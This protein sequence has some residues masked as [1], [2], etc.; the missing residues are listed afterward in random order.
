MKGGAGYLWAWEFCCPRCG[1]ELGG[2]LLKCLGSGITWQRT[3]PEIQ[4]QRGWRGDLLV[5]STHRAQA[6]VWLPEP[7]LG[8]VQPPV[9]LAPG[10]PVPLVSEGPASMCTYPTPLTYTRLKIKTN[11][12]EQRAFIKSGKTSPQ[13]S[14]EGAPV[15][16]CHLTYY[17]C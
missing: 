9:T 14:R 11:L 17:I 5:K 15:F 1:S 4:K 6:R 10:D 3:G 8:R 2:H 16:L 13:P 7:M 12:K